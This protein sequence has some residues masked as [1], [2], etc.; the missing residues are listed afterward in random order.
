MTG[1]FSAQTRGDLHADSDGGGG[2]RESDAGEAGG[3]RKNVVLKGSRRCPGGGEVCSDYHSTVRAAS[4]SL[5]IN[6]ISN[7][8][9]P[10]PWKWIISHRGDFTHGGTEHT[11]EL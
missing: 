10:A 8:F 11:E 7:Y 5:R 3:V 1:A 4:M 2:E 6:N 9:E